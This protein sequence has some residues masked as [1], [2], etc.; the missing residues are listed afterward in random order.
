M[1]ICQQQNFKIQE[2]RTELK[3]DKSTITSGYFKICFTRIRG[4]KMKLDIFIKL[5]FIEHTI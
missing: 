3:R 4:H 5:A 1:F 2:A